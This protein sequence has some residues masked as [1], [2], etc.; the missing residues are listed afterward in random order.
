MESPHVVQTVA[1]LYYY[2][3]NILGHCKKYF[4]HV[5]S[6]LLLL[7]EQGNFSQLKGAENY[8]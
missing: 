8:A 6:L 4:S 5:F 1:E 7:G 2:Y 3:P